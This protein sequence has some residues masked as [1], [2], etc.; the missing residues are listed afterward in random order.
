MK[1]LGTKFLLL[2]GIFLMFFSNCNSRKKKGLFLFFPDP[3]V[4][5]LGPEQKIKLTPVDETSG[6]TDTTAT[7]SEGTVGQEQTI[8]VAEVEVGSGERNISQSSECDSKQTMYFDYI[9]SDLKK[10]EIPVFHS[11]GTILKN[12]LVNIYHDR[13][14]LITSGMADEDGYFRD[15]IPSFDGKPL[16]G[17]IISVG[18]SSEKFLLSAES[19]P[20][21]KKIFL[22]NL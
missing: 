5:V 20:K 16:Y 12:S 11:D 22:T 18:I 19:I 1:A 15:T 17:Q 21:E 2:A 9:S 13:N 7:G 3:V 10:I 6:D 14:E 4:M 8:A